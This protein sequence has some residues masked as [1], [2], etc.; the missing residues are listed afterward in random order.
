MT[1]LAFASGCFMVILWFGLALYFE[2]RQEFKEPNERLDHN[3]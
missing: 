1:T 3:H 2:L